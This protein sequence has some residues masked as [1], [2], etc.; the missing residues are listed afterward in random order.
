MPFTGYGILIGLLRDENQLPDHVILQAVQGSLLVYSLLYQKNISG[1]C[2]SEMWKIIP[3][4][5]IELRIKD[6]VTSMCFCKT[7]V[8]F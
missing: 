8:M 6:K 1:I 4:Y 5:V 7:L 3:I 2:F